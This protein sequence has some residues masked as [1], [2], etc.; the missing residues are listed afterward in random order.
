MVCGTGAESVGGCLARHYVSLLIP[1]VL[2]L[3]RRANAKQGVE[4]YQGGKITQ[5]TQTDIAS[6]PFI[7]R[8]LD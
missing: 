7:I 8:L 2:M 1:A 4:R 6:K 5:I 3:M